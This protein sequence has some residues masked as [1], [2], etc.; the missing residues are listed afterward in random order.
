LKLAELFNQKTPTNAG[1]WLSPEDIENLL[2]LSGFDTI[3]EER[4]LIFPKKVPFLHKI[5]DFI[6]SL[7]FDKQALPQQLYCCKAT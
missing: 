1:N 7:P 4:R 5:I 2:F 6:G 3:K